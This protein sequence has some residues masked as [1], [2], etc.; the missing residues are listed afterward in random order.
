MK[1]RITVWVLAFILMFSTLGVTQT[2]LAEKKPRTVPPAAAPVDGKKVAPPAERKDIT[3]E[4]AKTYKKFINP[5][6]TITLQ[7]LPTVADHVSPLNSNSLQTTLPTAYPSIKDN[8]SCVNTNG[9]V[10]SYPFPS[11]NL[12]I[13]NSLFT[14]PNPPYLQVV[15]QA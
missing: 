13:Q 14:D 2:T 5:S 7:I 1:S 4:G 3:P 6:G 9:T 11:T 12:Y 15:K 8:I 10:Q